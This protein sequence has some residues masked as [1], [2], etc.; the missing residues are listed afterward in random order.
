MKGTNRPCDQEPKKARYRPRKHNECTCFQLLGVLTL[1]LETAELSWYL[2]ALKVGRRFGNNDPPQSD[3]ACRSHV[4]MR[5]SCEGSFNNW[6]SVRISRSRLHRLV[7]CDCFHQ[8]S[9]AH[10]GSAFNES[11]Q[12]WVSSSPGVLFRG[13][14][15][16]LVLFQPSLLP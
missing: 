9:R 6:S 5:T 15:L 4:Q 3:H 7:R 1:R 2:A 10:T 16:L 13:G 12:R 11:P 8:V 14:C